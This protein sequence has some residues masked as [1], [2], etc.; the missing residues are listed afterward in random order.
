[1][2]KN[3]TEVFISTVISKVLIKSIFQHPPAVLAK[4]INLNLSNKPS[5]LN[6]NPQPSTTNLANRAFQP[7][8]IVS[9]PQVT[10]FKP[11][12]PLPYQQSNL[13]HS[14]L[15]AQAQAPVI[16]HQL[17]RKNGVKEGSANFLDSLLETHKP[18]TNTALATSKLSV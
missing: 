17:T 1:L 7:A 18:G 2:K 9:Y 11:T 12:I 16:G 10:Q 15:L 4:Q 6:P 14:L 8:T 3:L 5:H 13:M